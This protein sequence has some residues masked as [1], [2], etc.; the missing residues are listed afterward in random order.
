MSTEI[1][2]GG[3]LRIQIFPL[4]T[5]ML[6]N[7]IFIGTS[8]L[9]WFFLTDTG[10]HVLHK[11]KLMSPLWLEWSYKYWFTQAED[12]VCV[13]GSL[14]YPTVFHY[15]LQTMKYTRN[16]EHTKKKSM[17]KIG[18]S[19]ISHVLQHKH[20]RTGR[21]ISESNLWG[22]SSGRI[23]TKHISRSENLIPQQISNSDCSLRS[24]SCLILK[25]NVILDS[26]A[27]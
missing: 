12:L 4:D 10:S 20:L 14:S 18:I 7:Q 8:L 21:W 24:W 27:N 6:A 15:S 19:W 9:L 13:I 25:C 22:D 1:Y 11:Q 3:E 5:Q 16:L 17:K 26:M 23:F 2:R